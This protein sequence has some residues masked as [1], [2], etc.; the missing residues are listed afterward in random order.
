MCVSFGAGEV[1]VSR[2]V[3][4]IC[5]LLGDANNSVRAAAMETLVDIY[6]HVG[7]KLRVDMSKRDIPA[8]KMKVLVERFNEVDVSTHS[9][10]HCSEME[11]DYP[12]GCDKWVWFHCFWFSRRTRCLTP[13]M[14]CAAGW[15]PV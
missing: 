2:H 7:R 14:V 9:E 8:A 12:C 10:N 6:R 11:V 4:A 5:A 13:V 1:V 3:D 15:G